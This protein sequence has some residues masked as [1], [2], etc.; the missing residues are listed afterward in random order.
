M[1]TEDAKKKLA[2]TIRVDENKI[3]VVGNTYSSVFNDISYTQT[4]NNF[5]IQL[6]KKEDAEFRLM[7]IAHNHPSKNLSI[8][9]NVLPLLENYNV[10]FVLTLDERSFQDLFPEPKDK[11][12][13]VG[14][15]LINF[16][17]YR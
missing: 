17:L 6:P 4:N 16:G 5:Y 11:I 14:T 15:I 8:I 10:K 7:Y 13:N 1:E 12:I 3:F 9:N 2:K